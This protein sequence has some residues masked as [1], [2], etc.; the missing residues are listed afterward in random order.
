L[1]QFGADLFGEI[2]GEVAFV[3]RAAMDVVE[4]AIVWNARFD[5]AAQRLA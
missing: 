2:E 5:G 1:R 3:V 4:I